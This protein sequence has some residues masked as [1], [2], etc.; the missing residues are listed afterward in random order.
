MAAS[1]ARAPGRLGRRIAAQ[2]LLA[3]SLPAAVLGVL[4]YGSL[5]AQTQ[6][7]QQRRLEHE[8]GA[9]ALRVFDRLVAARAALRLLAARGEQPAA[10]PPG[11]L[12]T[13]ISLDDPHAAALPAEP[14]ART[15]LAWWRSAPRPPGTSLHWKAG[16][17]AATV[18]LVL[19]QAGGNRSW[20]AQVDA[21]F[22]WADVFEAFDG[23]TAC[24]RDAGHAALHCAQGA[25]AAP[26]AEPAAGLLHAS[27]PLFLEHEFGAGDWRFEA[28]RPRG[29]D[30]LAGLPLGSLVA[31]VVLALLLL[32]A[33][34][35][36]AQVR[37]TMD[38]LRRLVA[39]TRR[40]ARQDYAARVALSGDDEFRELGESFN[41]MAT[42]MQVHVRELQMLSSMDREILDA[43]DADRLL[44]RALE[45]LGELAPG[46]TVAIVVVDAADRG[47]PRLQW[48]SA[49]G[50]AG[51][52]TIDD[53]AARSLTALADAGAWL[54]PDGPPALAARRLGLDGAVLYR[55]A[56]SAHGRIEAAVLVGA[57][58]LALD[59]PAWRARIDGLGR[60]VAVALSAAAHAR[61]LMR[62]ATHDA[63]TG[64]R[65]RAGLQAALRVALA[66]ERPFALMFADL[67]RFKSVNDSLG[68]PAGDALLRVAAQRLLDALPPETIVARPGGDE[69]VLLLDTGPQARLAPEAAARAVCACLGEVFVVEGHE[70]VLGAS[71][72]WSLHPA[73]GDDANTLLRRADLA[74][75]AAK[76]AGGARTRRYD[77]ALE[78]AAEERAW[79]VNE[80]PMAVERGQ[81]V[82]HYQPRV[83]ARTGRAHGAEALVRWRHPKHGLVS[84]ARFIPAAEETGAIRAIGRWV[85]DE[86]CRQLAAWRREG[87]AIER[88][89]VNL[90]A[91]QLA[92]PTL[93][94]EVRAA[95]VR[96]RLEGGR[97]ELEVT[98]SM[99]V[100]DGG[101]ATATLT[102]LRVAGV[103]IALDDFGTGYSSMSYLGRMPLDVMKIDRAFVRDLG[104]GGPADSVTRAI[105]ALAQSLRLR[106][107]AEGVET[108][109]QAAALRALGCDELQ[110]FL[111]AKPL[112]AE[113][114][115]H[116][117]CV[118]AEA[119]VPA[120]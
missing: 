42:Q 15:L 19:H 49:A 46:A 89:S 95:L 25:P 43:A 59:A 53:D 119:A 116:A 93:F 106:L 81:L 26:A 100:D 23:G 13:A 10:L 76:E 41:D 24:V 28:S 22:L 111:Y 104:D 8:I 48:R 52:T 60:R 67:D 2:F 6:E 77:A 57:A 85:L 109:A 84:P 50:G 17:D 47:R 39:V 21:R 110:G 16:G 99:L 120:G 117:A 61:Q 82:V 88:V 63:L 75:Y 40:L 79:I 73:D 72:G 3:A 86:A 12:F 18:V 32:V 64:L 90:S 54:E 35:S 14:E 5:R 62:E 34:L 74:M 105:V 97:L 4:A 27:K 96:H 71:V 9:D 68:H 56:A 83:D 37:R 80:L 118:A 51:G 112:S 114:Y 45:L 1:R 101:T 94:D 31:K 29:A 98:E 107:V 103:L 108:E 113:D 58:D 11:S 102:R 70:F 69:F 65:N 115:P 66:D 78:R 92:E 7:Q 91:R 38:P 36:L 55:T 87:V 33:V 30:A 44:E 20:L